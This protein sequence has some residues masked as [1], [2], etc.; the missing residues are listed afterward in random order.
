MDKKLPKYDLTVYTAIFGNYDKLPDA[1]PEFLKNKF[2]FILFS[3]KIRTAPGW[4]VVKI[5][6]LDPTMDNRKLKMFPWQYMAS[7]Y[8]VYIDGHV[9]LGSASL[10]LIESLIAEGEV[11]AVPT[12]RQGGDLI[13]EILRCIKNQKITDSELENVL[14]LNQRL[15]RRA[16]ECGFIFRDNNDCKVR[17]L[18]DNW[19]ELFNTVCKRDQLL[20][21]HAASLATIEPKIISASFNDNKSFFRVGIHKWA[22]LRVI[23]ARIK[24]TLRYLRYGRI[25]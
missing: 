3:D 15:S 19:W 17:C 16:C 1:P 25:L 9:R 4:D 2:N 18:S 13:N 22:H 11:I 14:R 23:V 8:S 7:R 10:Q 20:F 24:F 6:S 21:H 12:H 5:D